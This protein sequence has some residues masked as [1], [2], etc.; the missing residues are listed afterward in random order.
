VQVTV[1][2]SDIITADVLATAILSGGRT[3]LDRAL[4]RWPLEVI[5]TSASG[6]YLTTPAFRG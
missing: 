2:A 1:V 4:T 5:A 3:A 6:E